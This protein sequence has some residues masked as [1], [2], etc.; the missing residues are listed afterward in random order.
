MTITTKNWRVQMLDQQ[1]DR[2]LLYQARELFFGK[3]DE[4]FVDWLYF[5]NPYGEV[6]C[7]MALDGDTIAGQY[8]VIPVDI[9]VSGASLKASLSVNAFTHPDYRKQGIYHTLAQAVYSRV[10][11]RG[12]MLTISFPNESRR[13]FKHGFITAQHPVDLMRPLLRKSGTDMI[14][15]LV[16]AFPARPI[17]RGIRALKGFHLEFTDTLNQEWVD[18]LWG[19]CRSRV[20]IDIDKN[21]AWANWRYM[22]HPWYSYRFILAESKGGRPMGYAVWNAKTI[23]TTKLGLN[24]F[25]LM[26][27]VST[28][29]PTKI[30]LIDAF[31]ETVATE[32][33]AAIT[34]ANLERPECAALIACGFVPIN[35]VPFV[36]RVN[37]N[38]RA[39]VHFSKFGAWSL[40][41]AYSDIL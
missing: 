11:D 26:D 32:A 30:A 9:S 38:Q 35:R 18:E 41:P 13:L 2:L 16:A 22:K 10:G 25:N 24:A 27:I 12:L 3:R 19:H 40:S 36:L 28:D 23:K 6:F 8:M 39:N 1:K 29:L 33:E 5:D 31:L 20:P 14:R 34:I 17:A 15:G 37:E 4:L 7:A 21:G